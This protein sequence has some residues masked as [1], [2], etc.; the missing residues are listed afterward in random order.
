MSDSI[1]N[2]PL[3]LFA[4]TH[5]HMWPLEVC[6]EKNGNLNKNTVKMIITLRTF[7]WLNKHNIKTK[8]IVST[9]FYRFKSFYN[10]VKCN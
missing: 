5:L 1:I 2:A 8:I 4:V 6:F 9:E 7:I 10:E 3:H